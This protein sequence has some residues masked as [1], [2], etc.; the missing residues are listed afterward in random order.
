MLAKLRCASGIVARSWAVTAPPCT[1]LVVSM[2]WVAM[3]E[4][5]AA[6]LTVC[7]A[8]AGCM[9]TMSGR[10]VS[11]ATS[12]G[13]GAGEARCLDGHPIGAGRQVAKAKFAMLVAL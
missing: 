7:W 12:K 1:A 8:A 6:T 2:G 13:I 5:C 10:A 4:A 9:V 11:T 3:E